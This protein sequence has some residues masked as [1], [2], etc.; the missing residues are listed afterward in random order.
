M[1]AT[2]ATV[3]EYL[4][5]LPEETRRRVETVRRLAAEVVPGAGEKISYGIPAVTIDGRTVVQYSGWKRHVAV[6]PVPGDEALARD[7][8]PYRAGKGTLQ[9]PHDRPFPEDL[10]RRVIAALAAGAP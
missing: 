8:D 5:A 2:S 10:V 4:V 6:Y 1:A 7:L 3:E 9:F